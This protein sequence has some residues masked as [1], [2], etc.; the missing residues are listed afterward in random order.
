MTTTGQPATGARHQHVVFF[1]NLNLGHVG[2]PS[3]SV[4]VEAF[5]GPAV[6]ANFQTNGTVVIETT[7]PGPIVAAARRRLATQGFEHPFVVRSTAEVAEIV[8]ATPALDPAEDVYR[9]VV[10]FFDP[11]AAVAPGDGP[12]PWRS[13]NGLVEVRHVGLDHAVSAC[14]RRGSSVGDVTGFLEARLGVPVTTRT[15][16]TLERLVAKH[17]P[18]PR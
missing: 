17:P 11:S 6:A 1:R 7:A 3:G 16:G 4:L 12:V 13:S 14:W 10:S 15:L 2:S 5:G 9:L 8:A 18:A